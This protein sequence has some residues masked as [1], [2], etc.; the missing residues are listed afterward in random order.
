M[1]TCSNA[2]RWGSYE[3]LN[4][5]ERNTLRWHSTIGSNRQVAARTG[6]CLGIS[7]HAGS[8]ALQPRMA[9]LSVDLRRL[10]CAMTSCH[11]SASPPCGHGHCPFL[12]RSPPCLSAPPKPRIICETLLSLG[13]HRLDGGPATM[14]TG[15]AASRMAMGDPPAYRPTRISEVYPVETTLRGKPPD[16][17]RRIRQQQAKP[18]FAD[19]ELWL[20]APMI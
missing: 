16:E 12:W 3:D 7:C 10:K 18:L 4:G 9:C 20:K 2:F 1:T 5:R 15:S 6:A 17:R 8:S 13:D 14:L 19:F 11:W